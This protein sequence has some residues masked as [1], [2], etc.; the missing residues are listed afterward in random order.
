VLLCHVKQT[1]RII[2]GGL[3]VSIVL[4]SASTQRHVHVKYVVQASLVAAA[5]VRKTQHIYSHA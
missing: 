3:L 2:S 4:D 1:Q 5:H